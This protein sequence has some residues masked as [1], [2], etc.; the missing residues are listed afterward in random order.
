V[1]NSSTIT[2]RSTACD[3]AYNGINT[4]RC[5]KRVPWDLCVELDERSA[6]ERVIRALFDFFTQ[7]VIPFTYRTYTYMEETD[8]LSMMNK[9]ETK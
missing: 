8:N 7:Q 9:K 6:R 5:R 1:I 2:E 4:D 3:F